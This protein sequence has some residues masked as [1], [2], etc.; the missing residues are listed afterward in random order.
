MKKE[1]G[2]FDI[3]LM[4]ALEVFA[5]VVET[6]HVTRAAAMLGITQSAASQ[7]LKNLE[8][9]LGATLIDRSSRPIELTKAGTVLHRRSVSVLASTSAACLILAA[10]C[11]SLR[12]CSK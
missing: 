1:S 6:R 12:N 2:L 7:H 4:R 10:S 9:A 8:D 3:N 5:A 11:A